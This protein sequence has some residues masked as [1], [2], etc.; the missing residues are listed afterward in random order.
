MCVCVCVCVCVANV[1]VMLADKLLFV[2]SQMLQTS[3]A[4]GDKSAQLKSQLT[5]A[6]VKLEERGKEIANHQNTITKLVCYAGM[7][8]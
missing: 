1:N 4:S 6:Q 2:V 7:Y 8:V 3:G 5:E